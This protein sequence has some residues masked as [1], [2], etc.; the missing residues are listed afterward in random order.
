MNVPFPDRKSARTNSQSGTGRCARHVNSSSREAYFFPELS[1]IY[2][3]WEKDA[4]HPH[5]FR[6]FLKNGHFAAQN[7]VLFT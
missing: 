3:D 2:T 1:T 7:C 4:R 5:F 6:I